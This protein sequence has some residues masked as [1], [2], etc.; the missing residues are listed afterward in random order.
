MKRVLLGLA[1][2][3]SILL[4][5]AAPASASTQVLHFKSS[6]HFADALW[7]T[8]SAT[9]SGLTFVYVANVSKQG[10]ELALEQDTTS[11]DTNGQITGHTFTFADVTSGFSF[12]LKQPLASA[13]LSAPSLQVTTCTFDANFNLIG[14][15]TPTIDINVAW[16]GQGQITRTVLPI[17]IHSDGFTLAGQLHATHR[18]GTATGVVA[19]LTLTA[20]DLTGADLGTIKSGVVAVCV[21]TSC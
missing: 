6:R 3:A 12:A 11:F 14:C 1:A 15:T 20:S 19:G 18:D 2:I 17:H 10:P 13:S 4:A 5:T 7:S 9:S 8:R 21:G 16:T